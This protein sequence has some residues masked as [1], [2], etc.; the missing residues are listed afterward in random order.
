VQDDVVR[1]CS[2]SPVSARAPVVALGALL[3]AGCSIGPVEPAVTEAGI[4]VSVCL[5]EGEGPP[6]DVSFEVLRD[7]EVLAAASGSKGGLIGVVVPAGPVEVRLSD[8]TLLAEGDGDGGGSLTVSRG[9]DCPD[10]PGS[11]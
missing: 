6:G 8:G 4:T 2:A 11:G 1:W 7:G 3:L 5:G 10:P 9:P